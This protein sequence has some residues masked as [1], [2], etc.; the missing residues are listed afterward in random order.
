MRGI[1]NGLGV[2]SWVGMIGALVSESERNL[3]LG[4]FVIC[5]CLALLMHLFYIEPKDR[6]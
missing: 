3:W 2:C 5:A 1:R 6:T 4:V